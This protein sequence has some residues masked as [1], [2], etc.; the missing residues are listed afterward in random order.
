M[1]HV[2]LYNPIC[3]FLTISY[4]ICVLLIVF[5]N[6]MDVD[7]IYVQSNYITFH[8]KKSVTVIT[9]HRFLNMYVMTLF[10]NCYRARQLCFV[11]VDVLRSKSITDHMYYISAYY[12]EIY[13]IQN[14]DDCATCSMN[15]TCVVCRASLLTTTVR[16]SMQD[17][18]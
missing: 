6:Q 17:T 13:L 12:E 9:L 16:Y 15:N 8:A 2:I 7:N 10:F 1:H 3:T 11:H 4:T 5:V 18:H 14:K